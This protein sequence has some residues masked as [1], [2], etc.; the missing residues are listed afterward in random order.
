MMTPETNRTH[1]LNAGPNQ[2]GSSTIIT[3]SPAGNDTMPWTAGTVQA[4]NASADY[5]TP[6]TV[7]TPTPAN[8]GTN[9]T[10]SLLASDPKI[11]ANTCGAPAASAS[12]ADPFT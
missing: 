10:I 11:S 2:V 6:L 12:L 5:S 1:D 4:N 7:H 3:K 8:A 9:Q